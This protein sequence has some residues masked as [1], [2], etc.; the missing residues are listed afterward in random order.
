MRRILLAAALALATGTAAA[1]ELAQDQGAAIEGVIQSQI[2][3]FLQDDVAT[4]FGFASP[5]IRS[6]FGSPERFG[7]MVRQGYPMV[8]RP[9]S[10]TYLDLLSRSGGLW[11]VVEITD[12]AGQ[13]HYLGYQMV[14]VAPGDWRINGVQFLPAPPAAV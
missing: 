9:S 4:A 5:S 8:W 14:E 2:D 13:V 10:V 1:Q 11:Q 6:M 7:A 12:G 3:A